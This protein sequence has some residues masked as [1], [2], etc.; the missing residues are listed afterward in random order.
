MRS[1]RRSRERLRNGSALRREAHQTHAAVRPVSLRRVRADRRS[2]RSCARQ[3]ER[4][5]PAFPVHVPRPGRQ[6]RPVCAASNSPLR[7]PPPTPP[8]PPTPSGADTARKHNPVPTPRRTQRPDTSAPAPTGGPTPSGTCVKSDAVNPDR[9]RQ[10]DAAGRPNGR[11]PHLAMPAEPRTSISNISRR[12]SGMPSWRRPRCRCDARSRCT[13]TLPATAVSAGS[14]WRLATGCSAKRSRATRQFTARSL[15][16]L[17]PG[18]TIYRTKSAALE[19]CADD[20]AELARA[21]YRIDLT[22]PARSVRSR[23]G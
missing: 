21:V 2:T 3:V 18:G 6:A 23:P 13:G 9:V 15:A 19:R 7:P 11:R 22:A 17:N 20:L 16:P 1:R 10:A 5:S 4:P 8:A 12:R 14:C